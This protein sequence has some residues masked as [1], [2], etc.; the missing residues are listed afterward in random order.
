M[1]GWW[2]AQLHA[3]LSQGDVVAELPT[4]LCKFPV[5][6]LRKQQFPK[7]ITGW[8]PVDTPV[9]DKTDQ[10]FNVL[11]KWRS[12]VSLVVSHSCDLDKPNNTR[13]L[14][15]PIFEMST[16]TPDEQVEVKAQAQIARVPLPDIPG[17]GLAYADL[18]LMNATPRQSLSAGKRLLSVTD[19]GLLRL[20]AHLVEFF[21][22][23][24]PG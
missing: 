4:T 20:Q 22:R 1:S 3:Q 17:L 16:L 5:V 8:V 2:S 9:L 23:R 11:A 13:V 19:N 12:S 18:R 10:S 14:T 24:Q 15:V 21:L 7:G 6:H